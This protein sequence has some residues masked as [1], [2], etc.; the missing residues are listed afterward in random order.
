[1]YHK[2]PERITFFPFLWCF[3]FS[4]QCYINLTDY[5]N[6][7]LIQRLYFIYPFSFCYSEN[8]LKK[9]VGNSNY[10]IVA[11]CWII[12]LLRWIYIYMNFHIIIVTTP[13]Q[14]FENWYRYFGNGF[15]LMYCCGTYTVSWYTV[16]VCWVSSSNSR[17]AELLR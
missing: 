7:T 6:L 15:C 14:P 10:F 9:S 16:C 5:R 2:G 8:L 17:T 1:M 13:R 12:N 11:T 4:G 3:F